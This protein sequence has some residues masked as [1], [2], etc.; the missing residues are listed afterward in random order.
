MSALLKR[1]ESLTYA[2]ALS[3]IGGFSEPSKMPWVSWSLDAHDCNNGG[4]LHKIEGSVCHKCYAL[5]GNYRFGNVRRAQARRRA[6]LDHPRFVEAFIRALTV[7]QL[8]DDEDRFRWFDSGDLPDFETLLKIVAIAEGTPT[9]RHAL[10]TK[11]YGLLRK[12][13]LLGYEIPSNLFLR[14]SFPMVGSMWAGDRVPGDTGHQATVGLDN[15]PH[16]QCDAKLQDHKC[17]GPHMNCDACW[18]PGSINFHKH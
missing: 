16:T 13:R 3:I 4:R 7:R 2:D 1:Q 18:R 15:P 9:I 11:E 14:P 5:R 6:A 12:F 17:V 8:V 10:F